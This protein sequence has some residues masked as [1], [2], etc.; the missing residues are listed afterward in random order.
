LAGI[1]KKQE[2]T[3]IPRWRS[4]LD[5]ASR[6]ELAF[7][8]ERT[9]QSHDFLAEKKQSW[10]DNRTEWHAADL[11]GAA[12]ALHRTDEV[13][14]AAAFLI[15]SRDAP[16]SAMRLARRI[17]AKRDTSSQ[18][19]TAL[20][21]GR[22][23]K[24]EIHRA[25]QL[26]FDDPRN[27]IQWIELARQYTILGMRDR[28]LR[29]VNT[30]LALNRENRFVLRSAAR[31]YLH[32]NQPDRAHYILRSAPNSKGDPWLLA[33]EI[34]VASA[35]GSVSRLVD[36]GRKMLNLGQHSPFEV[37]EL[38]SALATLELSNGKNKNARNLFQH[39]LIQP[40]ENSLAQ[41]EW[42]A[43]KVR[44]LNVLVEDYTVAGKYEATAWDY[45]SKGEW[46]LALANSRAWLNDQPFSS[47]PAMLASYLAISVM[48]KFVDGISILNESLKANPK[49]PILLNNLAFG[50]AIT[51]Q[52]E[53]ADE[54]VKQIDL[55]KLT[56]GD[57]AVVTATK[58]LIAYRRGDV[59]SG[60]AQY[61]EALRMAKEIENAKLY[62]EGF[63]YFVQEELRARTPTSANLL[64]ESL[65][66]TENYTDPVMKRLVDLLW[67][68][69][70]EFGS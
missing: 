27:S 29:A 32:D 55:T 53:L 31:F 20:V 28:A 6:G 17:V 44:G 40:T 69:A 64:A 50:L 1:V 49:H 21:A 4:F 56:K 41:A 19:K 60:R 62:A 59:E 54:K 15:E 58:G 13:R 39:S 65:K 11:V 70:K 46:D 42:A 25:R 51:D 45:F 12:V 37:T 66:V 14:D 9:K 67:R 5:S 47:R 7:A 35:S 48:E 18:E 8:K 23:I 34:A 33:A 24:A 16:V 36:S 26:L 30:A 38:A 10:N 22:D 43:D 61:R 2:R 52:A 3:V 68:R 63:L 57:L